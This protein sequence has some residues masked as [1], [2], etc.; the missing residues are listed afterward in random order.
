MIIVTR[1]A[2]RAMS[3]LPAI[4]ALVLTGC[5]LGVLNPGVID[6]SKFDPG[7]DAGSL[8]LS[9]TPVVPRSPDQYVLPSR[10]RAATRVGSRSVRCSRLSRS[11]SSLIVSDL[12]SPRSTARNFRSPA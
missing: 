6:A 1:F 10:T 5:K 12:S 11:S 7:T 4:A 8:S 2:R 3:T 9:R